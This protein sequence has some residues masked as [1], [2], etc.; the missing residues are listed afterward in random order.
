MTNISFWLDPGCPWTWRT[1]RWLRSVAAERGIDIDWHVMSLA[2][3]NDGREIPE[4]Y[5][6]RMAESWRPV[7]L[8]AAADAEGGPAAVGR[9][10]DALGTM[11]HDEGHEPDD[12]EVAKALEAAGLPRELAAARDDTAYDAA[13]RDS[14]ARGQER[15]GT[16]SGSPVIAIDDGPGFFGPVV[17][18]PPDGDDAERLLD[19]LIMLSAVPTFSELKR[20]R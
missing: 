8:L 5:R 9:L 16:E 6:E 18:A 3:L 12:D 2:V 15:V 10:Y 7:R 14:H 4:A 17:T 13:V 1:S 19:A 11:T 20:A